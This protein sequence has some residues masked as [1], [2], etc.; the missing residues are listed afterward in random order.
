[1]TQALNPLCAVPLACPAA[2]PAHISTQLITNQ[3]PA[4]LL[5]FTPPSISPQSRADTTP[6]PP[7][8]FVF[9]VGLVL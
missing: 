8:T 6:V 9:E 5:I 7:A 3:A 2:L 4:N 1:M